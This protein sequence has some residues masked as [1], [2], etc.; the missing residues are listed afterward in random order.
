MPM[1][2]T[3]YSSY[4][5][6]RGEARVALRSDGNVSSLF[7]SGSAKAMIPRTHGPCPEV[8]FLNTSGGLTGGDRLSLSL[9]L[10]QGV[11][12]MAATQTAERA[13]ASP[14]GKASVHVDLTVGAGVITEI[15]E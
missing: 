15:L 6:A 9:D 8:V 5:R 12:A 10:A 1:F 3:P 14:D 11:T 4:Q 2:D 7:Q 13:Y